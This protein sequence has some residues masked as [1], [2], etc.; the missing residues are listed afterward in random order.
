M[1]STWVYVGLYPVRVATLQLLSPSNDGAVESISWPKA[2]Q[3][4]ARAALLRFI[5]GDDRVEI[6]VGDPSTSIDGT[7]VAGYVYLD[8]AKLMIVHQVHR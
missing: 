2:C 7:V 1:L 8:G 5:D 4:E 3:P 6:I